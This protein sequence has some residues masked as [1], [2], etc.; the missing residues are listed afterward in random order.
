MP[1]TQAQAPVA[2]GF[3]FGLATAE[4]RAAMNGKAGDRRNAT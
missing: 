1:M 4:E 2:W 3:L